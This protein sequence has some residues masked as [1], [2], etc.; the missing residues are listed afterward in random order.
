ML[1]TESVKDNYIGDIE[2]TGVPE[3]APLGVCETESLHDAMVRQSLPLCCGHARVCEVV[4][5]KVS[6]GVNEEHI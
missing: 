2:I 5:C 3:P 4:T 1:Q 6:T